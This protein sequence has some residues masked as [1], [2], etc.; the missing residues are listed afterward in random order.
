[1]VRRRLVVAAAAM[2]AL[3]SNAAAFVSHSPAVGFGGRPAARLTSLPSAERAVTHV[4]APARRHAAAVAPLNM[5]YGA[6]A[7]M[8]RGLMGGSTL[9]LNLIGAVIAVFA[10]NQVVLSASIGAVSKL[11]AMVTVGFLAAETK[12]L[13]PDA[14]VSLSKLIF[15]IFQPAYLLVNVATTMANP[16]ETFRTLG[17]IPLFAVLQI[18]IGSAVAKTMLKVAQVPRNTVAGREIEMCTS[19][20]NAGP[21]PLLFAGSLFANDPTQASRAVAFISFYLLGWSPAFWTKGRSILSPL[22]A[23]DGGGFQSNTMARPGMGGP[24]GIGAARPGGPPSPMG[25]PP[26]GG[27]RPG[28]PPS[29]M[30]GP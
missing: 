19:F 28:G 8:G 27:A 29:P 26:G 9:K 30:G 3:S 21:L 10:A 1:M 23:Q 11:V 5:N 15:S 17:V 12:A 20:G 14:C 7:G 16:T 22:G 6:A 2:A 13:T 18:A 25:G 4:R 24:P